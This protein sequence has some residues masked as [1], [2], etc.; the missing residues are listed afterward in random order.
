MGGNSFSV[1]IP[2]SENIKK[3]SDPV[4]HYTSSINYQHFKV[5]HESNYNKSNHCLFYAH[6]APNNL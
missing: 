4:I 1:Y 2:I 5:Y 6:T 3:L